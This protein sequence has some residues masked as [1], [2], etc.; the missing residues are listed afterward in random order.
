MGLD[1]T[2]LQFYKTATKESPTQ[3]LSKKITSLQGASALTIGLTGSL[4]GIESTNTLLEITGILYTGYGT[5]TLLQKEPFNSVPYIPKLFRPLLLAS[6]AI[7]IAGSIMLETLIYKSS[8]YLP[9]WMVTTPLL[10][11]AF[12]AHAICVTSKSYVTEIEQQ[13]E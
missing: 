1:D 11:G 6:S 2:I 9:S 7:A 8:S 3:N 10:F 4:I 12:A 5:I 13:K